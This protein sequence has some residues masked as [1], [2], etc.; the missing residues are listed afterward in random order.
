MLG[1]NEGIERETR[2]VGAPSLYIEMYYIARIL[3]SEI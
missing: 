3:Y 1:I 2:I